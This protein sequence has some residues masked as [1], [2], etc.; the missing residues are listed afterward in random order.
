MIKFDWKM[1]NDSDQH[2]A[3]QIL[4]GFRDPDLTIAPDGNPYL[5]R[6]YVVRSSSVANIYF[7]IQV[8]DDPER[9][10]HD[11]PWD[12]MSVILSGG[13]KETISWSE[14]EP[15]PGTTYVATRHVKDVIMRRA[16]QAHRLELPY[17][18][19]YTMTLF[20]TGPKIHNWGFWYPE[21]HVPYEQVTR[22]I[23]GV[24]THIK[25][26]SVFNPTEGM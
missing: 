9:P 21:G 17:G 26:R 3:M 15:T 19:P 14:G 5:Y 6:W 7:H 10:L 18:V 2:T 24:S 20:T 12:N 4:H 13:Y 23:D 1:L 25:P 8:A 22:T 11:H 16:K